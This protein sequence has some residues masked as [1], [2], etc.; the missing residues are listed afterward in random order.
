MK[1]LSLSF[2][3][4]MACCTPAMAEGPVYT[5]HGSH[6]MNKAAPLFFDEGVME[7]SASPAE[8]INNPNGARY[9][10]RLEPADTHPVDVVFQNRLVLRYE[11]PNEYTFIYQGITLHVFIDAG[12]GDLPDT[13][14][15]TPSPGFYTIPDSVTLE[16]NMQG[17]IEVH[18]LAMF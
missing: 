15:V 1:C 4:I 5:P 14:I 2:L 8:D 3:L 9:F 13:M 11:V 12:D 6:T 18:P 16:E 17:R 10:I 7:Y